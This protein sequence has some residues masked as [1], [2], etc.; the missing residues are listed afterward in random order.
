MKKKIS[1]TNL[2]KLLL[3]AV[4][5]LALIQVYASHRLSTAGKLVAELEEK[6]EKIQSEN[7]LLKE[8]INQLGSLSVIYQ[9]AQSLG[10]KPA[11]QIVYLSSEIPVAM[12]N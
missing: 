11:S 9:K 10:F 12:G 1:K 4:I 5:V 7:K 3:A 6:A 2:L 8:E